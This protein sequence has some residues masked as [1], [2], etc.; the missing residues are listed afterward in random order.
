MKSNSPGFLLQPP[1]KDGT[2]F[3]TL[4]KGRSI[5]FLDEG[6]IYIVYANETRMKC[7]TENA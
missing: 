2:G 4:N 5:Y 1:P 7:L 3:Y 6:E